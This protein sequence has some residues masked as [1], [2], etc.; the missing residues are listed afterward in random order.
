MIITEIKRKGKS[1]L[2]YV[3]ADDELY[4]LLQ[5]E[6]IY[7]HKLKT[8]QEIQKQELD[9]IKL[10]SDKLTCSS[11]ALNYVSKMIKS[12]FQVR[13]HL[14]KH[15]FIDEAIDESI[16]KLKH[17]GYINDKQVANFVMQSLEKRKGKNYIKK[18]LMQK[19]IKKEQIEEVLENLS[20]Q[21]E[22][23][24]EMAKKWLKTKT[25]PLNQ[26]DKAKL[27]RFLAGKGFEFDIIRRA[28]EKT[29]AGDEDDWYWFGRE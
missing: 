3:Y 11:K 29:K 4:G 21:E 13:Q 28:M 1:E 6:F 19:G 20:G 8:G 9:K 18:D 14:K 10:Q 25:I 22:T 7:K 2:Y 12:E 16:E 15:G 24:L 23:C 5:A 26:N 27:Y 17:Y